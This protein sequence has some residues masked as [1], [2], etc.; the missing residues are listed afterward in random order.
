[1]VISNHIVKFKHISLIYALGIFVV[2]SS[3]VIASEQQYS[4]NDLKKIKNLKPFIEVNKNECKSIINAL[5]NKIVIFSKPSYSGNNAKTQIN[6]LE[7]KCKTLK[8]NKFIE[9]KIRNTDFIRALSKEEQE[10][11]GEAFYGSENFKLFTLS[12]NGNL[13]L[14]YVESY[15]SKVRDVVTNGGYTIVSLKKCES[16]YIV[17]TKDPIDH[18]TKK[19]KNTDNGL[20]KL[21][22][23]W[24]I[25]DH[26]KEY[27]ER[28][29]FYKI[30]IKK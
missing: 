12:E 11:Y 30:N 10:K 4:S 7:K 25:Y 29:S 20:F 13:I 19:V 9:L 17:G 28:L 2:L 26:S 6:E 16:K 14:S 23:N 8:I 18:F 15:K 3:L 27:T 24:W 5:S 1:M 22:N 21:N